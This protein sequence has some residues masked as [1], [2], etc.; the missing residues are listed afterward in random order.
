M[1]EDNKKPAQGGP[2][3]TRGPSARS[4]QEDQLGAVLH[5][6]RKQKNWTQREAAEKAGD[7]TS[8]YIALLES[9]R[10]NPS[11]DKLASLARAYGYSV[12][13]LV[14]AAKEISEEL[15]RHPEADT[16]MLVN[17]VL[18]RFFEPMES[19][20]EHAM[21]VEIGGNY[22]HAT[23]VD[24]K[25]HYRDQVAAPG[26]EGSPHQQR[27]SR[28][29]PPLA[30]APSG[31]TMAVPLDAVLKSPSG[32]LWIHPLAPAR[33][34]GDPA[35]EPLA[36][37]YDDGRIV[38]DVTQ[39]GAEAQL[40]SGMPKNTY[41]R[42]ISIDQFPPLTADSPDQEL[43]AYLEAVIELLPGDGNEAM[44]VSP[45]PEGKK[46]GLGFPWG[47]TTHVVTAFN[48]RGRLVLEAVNRERHRL[49]TAD[50]PRLGIEGFP[51]RL[52]V[53]GLGW[54]EIA[55]A[56]RGADVE[57]VLELADRYEQQAI[58]EWNPEHRAVIFTADRS[59]KI[60]GWK[61]TMPPARR[62][63]S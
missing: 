32:S 43:V 2:R 14:R 45:A 60:T 23:S 62:A 44:T 33:P 63:D 39:L 59:R 61:L 50:L 8:S 55:Y 1:T 11:V 17:E 37:R 52:H 54:S 4:V 34:I 41:V 47:Q 58:Y 21:A 5:G 49:L 3:P 35:R 26:T 40:R 38:L 53:A 51:A 31:V 12:D 30:V 24:P 28:S 29:D 15:E 48:P 56:V 22:E 16:E 18:D 20:Y 19:R 46:E 42:C 13:Q 57:Q 6:L 36:Q 27:A 9:S 25:N 7:L 10:R